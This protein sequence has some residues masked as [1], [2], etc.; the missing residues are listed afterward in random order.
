MVLH[1]DATAGIIRRAEKIKRQLFL[2]SAVIEAPYVDIPALSVSDCL[3]EEC[4]VEDVE[5]WLRKLRCDVAR[6]QNTRLNNEDSVPA[7]IVVDF[8]WVLIHAS[9][10]VFCGTT[11]L[12][13]LRA[14]FD[15]RTGFTE[16]MHVPCILFSCTSRFI[17]RAARNLSRFFTTIEAS[18][19]QTLLH[20]MA[21]LVSSPTLNDPDKMCT[22]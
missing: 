12:P 4:R 9:I 1:L 22:R 21:A 3:M 11:I 15:R 8:S 6:L 5:F 13:Y 18:A 19:R 10:T 17:A 2:F 7:I 14:V 20:C 16:A